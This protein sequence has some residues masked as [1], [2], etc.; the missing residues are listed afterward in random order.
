[1]PMP[2]AGAAPGSGQAAPQPGVDNEGRPIAPSGV[3]R[4]L[5]AD[6]LLD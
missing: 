4:R 6:I 1:M 2:P 3:R 5:P